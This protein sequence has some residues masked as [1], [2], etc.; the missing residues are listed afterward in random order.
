VN[1]KLILANWICSHFLVIFLF[2]PLVTR[3]SATRLFFLI[4]TVFRGFN[5]NCL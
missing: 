2:Y 4:L 5:F 1:Q 3:N